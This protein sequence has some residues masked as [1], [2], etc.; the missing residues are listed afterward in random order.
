M[1]SICDDLRAAIL[2]AAMQGKLTEQ[3]PEDGDAEEILNNIE[4]AKSKQNKR[5]KKLSPILDKEKPFMLPDN[6]RWARLGQVFEI[7]AGG[8]PSRTSSEYWGGSI[9]WVKIG[10]MKGKYVNS[11]SEFITEEGLNNSSAKVFEEGTLLYSV[12]ASIGAVSIL[13]IKATTN[14]AIAG[15]SKYANDLD[16]DYM[17]WALVGLKEVLLGQAR[18]MAQLN[19]NQKI[20]SNAIVP[21]PP[22]SEQ[23][24]IAEKV[25]ELMARVADLEQSADAL[26]SLKKAFPDDIKASLLQA[27]MQGKL[28]KQ[29]PEDGDAEELLDQI[30]AEKEK[31]IAEGKIKKQK[32]L[33]P[34]TG[35]EIPFNIPENWK[36]TRLSNL[37]QFI[38][39]DRGKNYPSKNKLHASGEIPFISAINM[40]NGTIR[41]D[42]L[43]YADK[44]TY[45]KLGSGK[46]NK[47]DFVICIRGSLGKYCKYPYEL[48]AIASSLIIARKYSGHIL[49]DYIEAYLQSPLL[50]SEIHDKDNGTAQP[51]LSAADFMNFLIPIPPLAEQKRIAERLDSLM[52]NINVVGE[53]ISS[54]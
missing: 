43:L 37:F 49:D 25:D 47:D 24:R 51:N 23:K 39:G 12:F 22:F 42:N 26:A 14:Q 52:Q 30:K 36:W 17:Y 34:I 5:L 3:L 41:E 7:T 44:P 2:Q 46:L 54:E 53:L 1:S 6:W 21:I 16:T 33:A 31:L 28:T 18:G 9:P 35:D 15:L 38:N 50:I 19:I 4:L 32:P 45:D 13:G 20:L 10:D 11:T 40:Q 8:T 48:G 27:A 29:L